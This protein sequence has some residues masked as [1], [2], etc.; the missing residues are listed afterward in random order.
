MKKAILKICFK[1]MELL[2]KLIKK[3]DNLI[4]FYSNLGFRD[5]VRAFYDYLMDN[6]FNEKYRIIVSVNDF[7]KFEQNAPENVSF[8]G[9]VK[10]IKW[11]IKSKYAFY[12]FGKYPIKPSKNQTVVNLWH[13]TPL[14]RIGNLEQGCDKV[15]YNYFSF[16][17]ASANLY[18]PI[19][20]EIFG[21][22]ERNVE[23][24]GNPRNDEMFCEN[25]KI[26]SSIRQNYSRVIVWLPTYREYK[27]D[28]VVPILNDRHMIELNNLLEHKNIKLVIK[29][30]PLQK[31]D[32]FKKFSNI[33]FITE[34]DISDRGMT[35]YGLLR[36]ADGLI[37]DYSSVYFDYLLLDRPIGFA[38]E[39]INDYS[40]KRGFIFDNPKEYMPGMEIHDLE[41]IKKF[42]MDIYN[43][44]DLYKE[45][46]EVIN[47]KVNYYKDG[48]SAKRIAVKVFGK[49][50]I[51]D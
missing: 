38:I 27:D 18:V 11:F 43:E 6:K 2:N 34:S 40:D 37:T 21:C 50:C 24:F 7:Q 3:D 32:K 51:C 47:N 48:N 17:V 19:M 46:R 5:N 16:V 14:K 49:D 29:L 13:G 26:D 45:N 35:V 28:F 8:I 33:E 9:N 39:D 22:D 4:F 42:I 25:K 23:V 12:C 10:G 15:D 44:K 31:T 36:N 1:P 41:D 20:A 30:H